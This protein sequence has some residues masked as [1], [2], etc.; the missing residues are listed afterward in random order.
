MC[1]RR[2]WVGDDCGCLD[3]CDAHRQLHRKFTNSG[4]GTNP[5]D[6]NSWPLRSPGILSRRAPRGFLPRRQQLLDQPST[7]MRNPSHQLND[8]GWSKGHARPGDRL[9]PRPFLTQLSL[10]SIVGF[11][12]A[13]RDC[14]R[15]ARFAGSSSTR[16]MRSML[17]KLGRARQL[18]PASGFRIAIFEARCTDCNRSTACRSSLHPAAPVVSSFLERAV[19][20]RCIM[21]M[22]RFWSALLR[23]AT[24]SR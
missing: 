10:H 15:I 23:S 18:T 4:I 19:T 13:P 11:A 17:R 6:A 1:E 3:I 12:Q 9:S 21:A 22:N 16:R 24:V 5:S 2:W 14:G 7:G 8:Q 20:I